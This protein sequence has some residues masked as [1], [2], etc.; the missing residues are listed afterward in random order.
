[1]EELGRGDRSVVYRGVDAGGLSVAIKVLKPGPTDTL[2]TTRLLRA[3]ERA[4]TLRTPG[5]LP[6]RETGLTAPASGPPRPYLVMDLTTAP[7][8]ERLLAEGGSSRGALLQVHEDA[9]RVVAAAAA[10]GLSHG[11]IK[12]SNIFAGRSSR[13][14][15]ADFG[16]SRTPH[17]PSEVEP[18]ALR[19]LGG[20]APE[21]VECRAWDL[22]RATGQS[23]DPPA[24]VVENARATAAGMVDGIRDGDT[25]GDAAE[26]PA[27]ASPIDELAAFCGRNV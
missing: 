27:G 3:A 12:A 4:A 9:A 16:L 23:F 10:E 18:A 8:L 17:P 19:R 22:A 11:G 1:M 24:D 7:T 6:I 2:E 14:L 15:V 26:V 13:V 25:F 5:V 20:L 21:Q